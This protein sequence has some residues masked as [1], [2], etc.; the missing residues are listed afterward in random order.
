MGLNMLIYEHNIDDIKDLLN[1][2]HRLYYDITLTHMSQQ[3][4]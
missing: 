3:F 1:L 2:C 4:V